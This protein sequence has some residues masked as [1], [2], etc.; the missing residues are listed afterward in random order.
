MGRLRISA[1]E[2]NYKEIDRQ[3]R[4]Q[5]IHGLNDSDMSTDIMSELT[6]IEDNENITRDQV[7][8]LARRVEAQKTNQPS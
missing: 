6:K 2:C 8:A 7:L 4:E 3:L 1:R 5:F